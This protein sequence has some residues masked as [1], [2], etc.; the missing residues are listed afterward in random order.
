MARVRGKLNH[1]NFRLRPNQ[2]RDGDVMDR[3]QISN[4]DKKLDDPS[5]S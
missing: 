1:V 5:E 4:E 3:K 2:G